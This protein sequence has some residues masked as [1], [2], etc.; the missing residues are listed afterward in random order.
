MRLQPLRLTPPRYALLA[1]VGILMAALVLLN[2]LWLRDLPPVELDTAPLSFSS[3]RA[4]ADLEQLGARFPHR[5]TGS[6]EG[7]AASTW[8]A[9]QFRAGGLTVQIEPFTFFAPHNPWRADTTLFQP[10]RDGHSGYEGVNVVAVSPGR[11]PEAVLLVAHRD[12]VAQTGQGSNDNGSGTVVLIELARALSRT[13]HELTYIFASTDGEEE[14]KH[15]AAA[16]LRAHPEWRLRLALVVDGAGNKLATTVGSVA[17]GDIT[18]AAPL[19]TIALNHAVLADQGLAADYLN[20]SYYHPSP[21]VQPDPGLLT[22]SLLSQRGFG[23]RRRGDVEPIHVQGV[24]TLGV[25]AIELRRFD[26]ILPLGSILGFNRYHPI[27][28]ADSPEDVLAAVSPETLEMTG[29][30]TERYVRSLA[31]N[32]FDGDLASDDYVIWR[33]QYL[34][35]LTVQLFTAAL[36]LAGLGMVVVST[37]ALPGG[38]AAA[39]SAILAEL[40]HVRL[41]A[42]AAVLGAL[43]L[44]PLRLPALHGIALIWVLLLIGGVNLGAGILLFRQRLRAPA[45]L[46]VETAAA[47]RRLLLVLLLALI[48]AGYALTFCPL[49]ALEFVLPA[50]LLFGAAQPRGRWAAAIWGLLFLAWTMLHVYPISYF[51]LFAVAGRDGLWGWG[52]LPA[53]ALDSA[54]WMVVLVYTFSPL[55]RA[56]EQPQTRML[57]VKE[58][59]RG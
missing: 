53:L 10:I 15:G 35:P 38:W 57:A 17:P 13:P 30:F 31:L 21:E 33:A 1:A 2:P 47:Q 49:A 41:I 4:Y 54:L 34:P 25:E 55:P 40:P 36:A 18:G 12:V 20:G 29:R 44:Q 43:L 37:H 11:S 59:V 9:E 56:A 23:V 19:W 42:L 7:R 6:A 24:P 52:V 16:L 5:V 50:L 22:A 32:P 46:P 26:Q 14:G 8:V 3:A 48:G 51:N 28:A 58:I 27:G 45:L 39:A